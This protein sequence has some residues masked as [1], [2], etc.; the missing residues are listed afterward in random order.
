MH[1]LMHAASYPM[2][3]LEKCN[4]LFPSNHSSQE[5]EWSWRQ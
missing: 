4:I 3:T 2:T 5:S 1:T